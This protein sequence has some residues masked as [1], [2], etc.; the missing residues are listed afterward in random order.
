M[1]F[2]IDDGTLLL[3][4]GIGETSYSVQEPEVIA[5]NSTD[6]QLSHCHQDPMFNATQPP[7][8]MTS[9]TGGL[10][11]LPA[12]YSK[13]QTY[14]RYTP[15]ICGGEETRDC[16]S[17][18]PQQDNYLGTLDLY[19]IGA[20]SVSIRGGSVLWVTG[21]ETGTGSHTLDSSELLDVVATT[22]ITTTTST[23]TTT[24]ATSLLTA[25]SGPDLPRPASGHC[26]E[27]VSESVAIFYGG[28]STKDIHPYKEAWTLDLQQLTEWGTGWSQLNSMTVARE[29]HSCGVIR[30]A[31][32]LI[33]ERKIVVAAGGCNWVDGKGK[34]ATGN[35]E[36]L[37]TYGSK[38]SLTWVPGPPMP[39]PVCNA[40]SDALPDGTRLFVAGGLKKPGFPWTIS[41]L[42]QSLQCPTIDSCQ[43]TTVDIQLSQLRFR[44]VGFGIPL[45]QKRDFSFE[46]T[47]YVPFTCQGIFTLL[48]YFLR[49]R[50]MFQ[51]NVPLLGMGSVTVTTILPSVC[52]ME[53]TAVRFPLTSAPIAARKR[54]VIVTIQKMTIAGYHVTPQREGTTFAM[55]STTG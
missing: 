37:H 47:T 15:V 19:R 14:Y 42:V 2:N 24:A 34:A 7:I 44:G 35:V 48:F 50:C 1:S 10:L 27:V 26:L 4:S 36:M 38:V 21:G 6:G 43:W 51:S 28:K 31:T 52:M 8:E 5:I 55:A 3:V 49:L 23:T 17:L 9:A 46:E 13:F 22:T 25:R 54:H 12:N 16:F 29:K 32:G 18:G 33:A 40:A 20:A 53:G 11:N 41:D 45:I 39:E 30:E